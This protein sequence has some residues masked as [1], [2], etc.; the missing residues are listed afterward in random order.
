M[1]QD[2]AA[3]AGTGEEGQGS[4]RRPEHTFRVDNVEIAIWKNHGAIGRRASNRRRPAWET[5]PG[6][7]IKSLSVYCVFL[8][9]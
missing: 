1:Q 7:K 2:N 5:E 8:K 6:L 9:R 4:A 3:R